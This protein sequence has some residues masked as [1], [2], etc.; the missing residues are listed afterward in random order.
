RKDGDGW[1]GEVFTPRQVDLLVGGA[2]VELELRQGSEI[3]YDSEV[4]VNRSTANIKGTAHAVHDRERCG[5]IDG[6]RCQDVVTRGSSGSVAVTVI[7][8]EEAP[9]SRSC[10][11][12]LRELDV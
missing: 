3:C 8:F 6:D 7:E 1:I 11:V 4:H 5:S 12:T 2:G 9:E 10:Y